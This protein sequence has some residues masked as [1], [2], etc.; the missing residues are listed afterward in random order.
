MTICKRIFDT[1][2]ATPGKTAAGLAK[3]LGVTTSQTTNWKSRGTDPPAK[4][5]AT[6]CKYLGVSPIWILSGVDEGD[7]SFSIDG[8]ERNLIEHFRALDYDGKNAVER[9]AINQ[10]DRVRYEGDSTETKGSAG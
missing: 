3:E 6:I 7:S 8:R 9:E 2:E 1:I 4:Y 5:I 10:H